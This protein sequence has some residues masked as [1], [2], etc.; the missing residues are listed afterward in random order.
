MLLSHLYEKSKSKETKSAH[1]YREQEVGCQTGER[2]GNK[3]GA[4]LRRSQYRS[5]RTF[6]IPVSVKTS[7][8]HLY[9][10]QLLLK[11][12]WV[13]VILFYNQD[14]KKKNLQ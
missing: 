1:I 14:C 11:T 13:A 8:I 3:I 9:V 7:K 12:K 10:E 6:I 4:N 2:F 5:R